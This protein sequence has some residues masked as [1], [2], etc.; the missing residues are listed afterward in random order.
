[1]IQCLYMCADIKKTGKINMLHAA[2][3][4]ALVAL[5]F[6]A[7]LIAERIT[8]FGDGTFLMFDLKRQ[9][10]DYY[11]Y[12]K[13]VLSGENN[14]RYSFS[15]TLGSGTVGFFAYYLTSPFLVILSIFD[16]THITTGIS[17]VI[18]LKLM[19]A[20]L[21]MD[22]FL[23]RYLRRADTILPFELNSASIYIG[24]VSWAFSGFLFAHSMNMM[25]TDVIILFPLYILCLELLLAEDRKVP[26]I[27]FLWAMLVLNYYITFQVII[28]TALW[29]IMRV[30]VLKYEKPFRLILKVVG[31]GV[32]AGAMSAA[33]LLP[34]GIELMN[35]PK[36]ITLLGLA[37][38]GKNLNSIDVLSKLPTL[39]YD[40][41]EARFGY[42]Q[43]YCGVLMVFLLLMYF[44]SKKISRREKIGMFVLIAVMMISFCLDIINIIWH[45]GME[46][47][48]HPYRQAYLFVF[49]MTVCG[50]KALGSLDSDISIVSMGISFALMV[51]GMYYIR[52]GGYD[53]ISDYSVAATFALI[54]FYAAVFV[55]FLISAGRKKK[56]IPVVLVFIMLSNMADLAANAVYTYHYQAMLSEKASDYAAVVSDTLDAVQFVKRQDSSFYR[57][58]NLKPRQQN[59]SLQYGYNG[60]T[61]YSSAGMVYVRYF[62]QRMGFNDDTLYTSYGRDNTETADSILGIKYHVT[63][64]TVPS[65]HNYKKIYDGERDVYENPYPLSIAIETTDY[66]LVGIYD[67]KGNEPDN[68]MSHVPSVDAFS[69]QEEIYERLL[70]REVDI[71]DEALVTR[72]E[73]VEDNGKY[74]YDYDVTAAGSGELYLYLDGL[75]GEAEGL[76]LFVDGEFL[77]S[78]GNASCTKVLNLGYRKRGDSL[79]VRVQGEEREYNFGEAHFVTENVAEL[80]KAYEELSPRNCNVVK[81][82]SSH[83][84]IETGDCNGLFLTVPFEKGWTIQVDGKIVQPVAIYDSLTYIPIDTEGESHVVEMTFMPVGIW[85]GVL[86]SLLGLL[87]LVYIALSGNKGILL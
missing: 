41:I 74:Y 43:I 51:V 30:I 4:A 28:F 33:L 22:A 84:F 77:T 34:T 39:S 27:V 18:G 54:I 81:N 78:Y 15:T 59:D 80:K 31:C 67:P 1:M 40:Y 71:F 3:S 26:F 60:I 17:I 63:D 73:L 65:H 32:V 70:K 42:P 50:T 11:A 76:S 19:L 49:L 47:S 25:W 29:T 58:E 2:L 61:H 16:Q 5:I 8:P 10:V 20:A 86:F 9:Y 72:S 12:Y 46:P 69:L 44:W 6:T 53:H 35:S 66:D 45:A 24:S 37:L 52:L 68:D 7:V 75:I 57:M 14:V 62:L 79:K 23:Q 82:T 21:I 13:T 85:I 56:L 87:V 64:E 55:I 83:I 38:T 36:D 48:G